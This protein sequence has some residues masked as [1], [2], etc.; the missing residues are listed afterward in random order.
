MWLIGICIRRR[1]QKSFHKTKDSFHK[2]SWTALHYCEA[3]IPNRPNSNRSFIVFC[4]GGTIQFCY[5]SMSSSP[6]LW[7]TGKLY[8]EC[9]SA[10]GLEGLREVWGVGDGHG[11]GGWRDTVCC[12]RCFCKEPF[13]LRQKGSSGGRH[14][15]NSIQEWL[16]D[17]ATVWGRISLM[18][19]CRPS[20]K[21]S[22]ITRTGRLGA[23]SAS[24]SSSSSSSSSVILSSISWSFLWAASISIHELSVSGLGRAEGCDKVMV[25][26]AGQG[27]GSVG[28]ACCADT[29]EQLFA[30]GHSVDVLVLEL[31]KMSTSVSTINLRLLALHPSSSTLR[32]CFLRHRVSQL[33]L[34]CGPLCRCPA[35][36]G[37]PRSNSGRLV[38][39]ENE[40]MAGRNPISP[41]VGAERCMMTE[42]MI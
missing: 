32:L 9:V 11:V 1:D 28:L 16:T 36:L 18:P 42:E 22:E 29:E 25:W 27:C 13:S 31:F 3:K 24:R 5:I 4:F 37:G 14:K 35:V 33:L 2:L 26:G 38:G 6:E 10:G 41:L 23:G 20:F 40:Y 19:R 15:T 39:P 8:R 30:A 17:W 7:A 34:E 12:L 21:L